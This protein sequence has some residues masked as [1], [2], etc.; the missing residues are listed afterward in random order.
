MVCI[1]PMVWQYF[2]IHSLQIG[3]YHGAFLFTQHFSPSNSSAPFRSR[4]WAWIVLLSFWPKM[5]LKI[6]GLKLEL[7]LCFSINS[8]YFSLLL[9]S[10]HFGDGGSVKWYSNHHISWKTWHSPHSTMLCDYKYTVAQ[11]VWHT[12][13]GK[14]FQWPYSLKWPIFVSSTLSGMCF[15]KSRTATNK[16]PSSR[17]PKDA[18]G[19]P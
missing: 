5:M 19:P 1:C 8:I 17:L 2:L 9:V 15:W 18:A 12:L 13:I 10:V 7:F 4:R 6:C 16:R 3:G 14:G 11:S